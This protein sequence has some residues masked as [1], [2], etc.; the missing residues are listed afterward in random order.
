MSTV[1]LADKRRSTVNKVWLYQTQS[2]GKTESKLTSI[3]RAAGYSQHAKH[4]ETILF[5]YTRENERWHK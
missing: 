2:T 4:I 1:G 5:C 3:L